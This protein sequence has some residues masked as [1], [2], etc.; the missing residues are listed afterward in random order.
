ME[1]EPKAFS[2]L[3]LTL[4]RNAVDL[5]A[6]ATSFPNPAAR[7]FSCNYCHRKFY[8]SQALGGH[9]NAHKRERSLAKRSRELSMSIRPHAAG[10]G[11]S[12]AGAF[13]FEGRAG[14]PLYNMARFE[15]RGVGFSSAGE[16]PAVPAWPGWYVGLE[17]KEELDLLP[18]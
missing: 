13:L 8:S 18:S 4:S 11:G 10:A 9:Q 12:P 2:S 5:G 15:R 17:D 6:E 16:R 3:D 14:A 1:L 7:V